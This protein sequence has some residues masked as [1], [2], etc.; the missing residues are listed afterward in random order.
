[1]FAFIYHWWQPD[2]LALRID[3]EDSTI[4]VKARV[5]SH[6]VG[7]TCDN[8][9]TLETAETKIKRD[10]NVREFFDD[11]AFRKFDIINALVSW[12]KPGFG[13]FTKTR[14]GLL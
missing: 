1:M 11:R 3:L 6:N 8:E 5:L 2:Y 9:S 10:S 13:S 14:C 4:S 7:S 12:N